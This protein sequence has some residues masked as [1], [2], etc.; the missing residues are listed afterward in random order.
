MFPK[1]STNAGFDCKMFVYGNF[2]SLKIALSLQ[3][4]YFSFYLISMCDMT[5][6]KKD[7][8]PNFKIEL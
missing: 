4:N 5:D 3:E 1:R 6:L 8:L 7:V 2:P